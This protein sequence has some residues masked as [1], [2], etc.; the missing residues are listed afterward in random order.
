[1]KTRETVPVI[2]P[3]VISILGLTFATHGQEQSEN[4]D[5]AT[6]LNFT[7]RLLS[8]TPGSNDFAL[9]MMRPQD[10]ENNLRR[11]RS[12]LIRIRPQIWIP[13]LGGK[14]SLE[15]AIGFGTNLDLESNLG[16]NDTDS[17]F[18]YELQLNLGGGVLK[19]SGFS[20]DLS[21]LQNT[22]S[23][24]TFGNLNL[25]V[26]DLVDT[27]IDIQNIKFQYTMPLFTIQNHGFDF[28]TS[29]GI[30]FYEIKAT[31]ID[32]LAVA[33]DSIKEQLPI[34]IAGLHFALPV[35]DFLI[36]ADISGLII[37]VENIDVSYIDLNVSISWEPIPGVGIFAG[38]RMIEAELDDANF[39][40][41][42]SLKGPYFGGEIRF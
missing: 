27:D 4:D 21:G 30:D 31:V 42:I 28:G 3:V 32:V 9:S 5:T 36:D 23:T 20:L 8:P 19:I 2:L 38:Y 41:D 25:D 16:I 39:A 33:T 18:A 6:D 26:N 35:G 34:P 17:M 10:E 40:T 1:M 22:L 37:S 24:F 15:D 12:S 7:D 13:D 29:F 11:S 14:I